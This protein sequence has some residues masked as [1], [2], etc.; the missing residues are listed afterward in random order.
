MIGRT[1]SH[2]K[3]LSQL[4]EGGMGI[5]YQAQ[6]TKLDRSVALKFLASHLVQDGELR[7]R[8]EREA[9]AA[10]SLNH[11]NICTVH[12]I[13]EAEGKTFISM[14]LIEGEPLDERIERGPLKIAEAVHIALQIAKGLESA[15]EKGV[16]H[17]DVKPANVMVDEKGHVTV[18]DFGLALLTEGSKLTKLDT[19]VGTVAYMSPEQAQGAAVDHRTDVWA[20]G[21]V[22]YEMV[23]GQRPFLG[24]YDQALLY[25]IVHEE[26]EPLTGLRTG[27]PI[28]LEVLVGK[29]LAKD[30]ED[31]P[32]SAEEVARDLRTLGDKLKSGR[33]T[34]LRTAAAGADV[35]AT[36]SF[37]GSQQVGTVAVKHKVELPWAIAALA[38]VVAAAL[39]WV[40][41]SQPPPDRPNYEFTISLPQTSH[42]QTLAVSPDGRHLVFAVQ[43]EGG[44]GAPLLLRS[45]DSAEVR[46]MAGTEGATF[47]FWSPDSR[48]IGFFAQGKLKK[49]A[50]AGGPA[51]SLCNAH[52]GRGGSWNEEGLIVFAPTPF[53]GFETVSAAG[54]EPVPVRTGDPSQADVSRRFPHF[55]PDGRHVLYLA[56]NSS[57]EDETGVFYGSIDGKPPKRLLSDQSSAI[58]VP[59]DSTNEGFILFIREGSL[60]ALPFDAAR[61]EVAGGLFPVVES[62][63]S[64]RHIGNYAFS[65]SNEGALAFAGE[66]SNREA[67]LA[68]FDRE[69]S[70]I[71]RI[72]KPQTIRQLDLSPDEQSIALSVRDDSGADIWLYDLPRD[73]ASR[74][75]SDPH[76]DLVP[77]WSP[78][79][80]YISF[81]SDR[82]GL[83]KAYKKP[84]G[85]VGKAEPLLA[86]EQQVA[87]AYGSDLSQDGQYFLFSVQASNS[88]YDLWAAPL[89][90][91][92]EAF[93][94]LSTEFREG[95][96]RFSPDTRWVAY[97]ADQSGRH[98]VYIRPFPEA[99]R[100]W[101]ISSEGGS[102]PRWRAD[103]KE[104]YYVAPDGTLMAVAI[105]AGDVIQAGAPKALFPTRIGIS[106]FG[107]HLAAYGVASEGKRF[108]IANRTEESTAVA[109]T[110]MTNW[111]SNPQH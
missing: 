28:E 35:A 18:M 66:R 75:T 27:V 58:Y 20:L 52:E 69:G 4:G 44:D 3:I 100:E 110:V 31:R 89:D 2:Y 107:T 104:L 79:G 12:E 14:A 61:L 1:I 46:E 42:L 86:L 102:Q 54:G 82:S 105:D 25:E 74:F 103:G 16:V 68:W 108:L 70:E 9:K 38:V 7:K 94:F 30:R 45:S 83:F 21:C 65:A 72:G 64:A 101:K 49:I 24:Q 26:P 62:V 48:H 40:L 55:L 84:A 109:L 97:V 106:N 90:G 56:R 50:L 91:R 80:A 57:G 73:T 67:Q 98:E 85:G 88:S 19:T 43:G 87:G 71:D 81:T 111:R 23:S 29:C 17:R 59:G 33:S 99:D 51:Q 95:S 60:M 53:G 77:T 39:A 36:G 32:S 96:G 10:A 37:A 6:D 92:R 34:I 93:A 22:L 15:H 5:V 76:L 13:D 41:F 11:P 47:P 78:D 63:G 8:F